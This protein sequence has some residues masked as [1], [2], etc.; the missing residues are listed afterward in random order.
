LKEIWLKGKLRKQGLC[1][2][3]TVLMNGI[4][5]Y[6]KIH[7][8]HSDNENEIIIGIK[9]NSKIQER[10]YGFSLQ[11]TNMRTF[12]PQANNEG[13]DSRDLGIYLADILLLF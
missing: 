7:I 10:G 2:Q 6:Y 5:V 3:L 11:L 4:E 9:L 8:N 13:E 12:N 1:D